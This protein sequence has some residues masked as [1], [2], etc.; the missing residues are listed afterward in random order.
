MA[1][2]CVFIVGWFLG[3]LWANRHNPKYD[4]TDFPS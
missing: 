4:Y 3:N 1:L 2:L